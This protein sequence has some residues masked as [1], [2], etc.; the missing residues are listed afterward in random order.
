VE[1]IE[2]DD[3]RADEILVRITAVGL[4][5]SD[6]AAVEGILPAVPPA[7]L[8]HEGAGIVESV[9][10]AVTKLKKGDHVVMTFNFCGKCKACLR[11]EPS[12]CANFLALNYAPVRADGSHTLCTCRGG[13]GIS[14]SFFGQ[15]SFASYAL[16]NE[17]NV[18]KVPDDADLTLLGPLGCGIQTGAG[19]VMRS[20]AAPA[21]S[22]IVV[23]GGGSVGLSAVMGAVVQGCGTI[24][25]VEPMQSRR[26]LALELGATHAINPIGADVPA[27]VREILPGGAEYA[28]DTSANVRAMEAALHSLGVRGSAAFLGVPTDV[29]AAININVLA[30]L[31]SAITIKFVIE[32]DSDPE[33]F[34]PQ[35]VGF[36]KAGR[37]PIDK[38]STTY[39]FAEI[40]TAAEDQAAGRCVKAILVF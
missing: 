27:L 25:L 6:L 37:F 33:V 16:G 7:V 18:I 39:P 14:G 29:T 30:A 38:I 22:S 2:I 23:F 32:G 17:R 4:C 1:E 19:T 24:I 34:I 36:Y 31:S 10:S 8:G 26:D 12:Y 21:G 40:N 11:G 20:L 28:V 15:S 9:G 5:H 35:L 13:A 3:P